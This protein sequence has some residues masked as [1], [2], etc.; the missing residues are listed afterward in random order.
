MGYIATI[1]VCVYLTFLSGDMDKKMLDTVRQ[2]EI[3]E[4]RHCRE[5]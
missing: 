3:S 5:E 1:R 2:V 4:L